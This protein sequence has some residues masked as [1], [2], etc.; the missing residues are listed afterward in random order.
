MVD[1]KANVASRH[2][3]STFHAW[4][5]SDPHPL[6][7]YLCNPLSIIILAITAV[8]RM[9]CRS[10]PT[11][12][13]CRHIGATRSSAPNELEMEAVYRDGD[14]KA[15]AVVGDGS[16]IQS[17]RWKGFSWSAKLWCTRKR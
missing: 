15:I 5:H 12:E 1:A 11:I 13:R 2:L 3:V 7:E 8:E 4:S 14:G 6:G 17:W 16:S 9:D 10:R